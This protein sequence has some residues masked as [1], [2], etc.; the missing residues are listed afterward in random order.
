MTIEAHRPDAA[1]DAAVAATENRIFVSA[2]PGSGKTYTLTRRARRL[3]L[4]DPDSEALLLTFTNKAADE[5]RARTEDHGVHR[6]LIHG[7]TFHVFGS[8]LLAQ[9]AGR[10]EK[11]N[12]DPEF[13]II[14][15]DYRDY[16]ALTV[17]DEDG[18]PYPA[19]L[20]LVKQ[21]AYHRLRGLPV[22]GDSD[23][24]RFGARFEAAKRAEQLLDF[25]D[26]VV[27]GA[28]LLQEN[29]DIAAEHSDG[30]H[31]L[32]DELQDI[33]AMH[34]KMIRALAPAAKTIS[35]F[36]D[37]DQSIM[38]FMGSD[39]RD[40]AQLV[41]EL[42]AKRYDL[43]TNHRSGRR[44][45]DA[46]N[47][48]IEAATDG[49]TE[50]ENE[51]E[52]S[53]T[54]G[55]VDVRHCST[56]TEQARKLATEI[57]EAIAAKTIV[58]EDVAILVRNRSVADLIVPALLNRDVEV[59]DWRP[60]R[61]VPVTRRLCAFFLE[62]ALKD[63]RD[64][65]S[66]YAADWIAR[67]SGRHSGQPPR[68]VGPLLKVCA[69]A[70]VA[71]VLI[72]LRGV[73]SEPAGTT[74]VAVDG[75]EAAFSAFGDAPSDADGWEAYDEPSALD[76]WFGSLAQ[77]AH[78]DHPRVIAELRKLIAEDPGLTIGSLLNNVKQ[79]RRPSLDGGGVKVGTIQATKG[80]EWPVVYLL[81]LE[82]GR[83]PDIHAV[84]CDDDFSADE[85]DGG[86]LDEERRIC[87]VGVTRAAHRL[88]VG[89]VDHYQGFTD[90]RRGS[91]FLK[92]IRE[93]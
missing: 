77:A 11:A 6:A 20:W 41:E 30:R 42:G 80:L 61:L 44:I 28:Q 81:G 33:N 16:V 62:V 89:H 63:D 59:T 93:R 66:K 7:S 79:V 65:V 34:A 39:P 55:V 46:G 40:V 91:R 90:T 31:L 15:D 47:R 84:R 72:T 36:G 19:A 4:S 87:F 86:S 12:I 85:V 54:N 27:Y 32:V 60:S 68:H 23:L 52:K 76:Q 17:E 10:L 9:H 5:M 92:Q 2:G 8:R 14:D 22:N 70:P 1:Q 57:A 69:G 58:A 73:L 78:D 53:A 82:E 49:R 26:L 51:P 75:L 29:P 25:D 37:P 83:L 74:A 67:L 21:W 71:D 24:G 13:V 48:V 35:L 43:L 56:D 50:R 64:T 3:L 88:V 18:E 38:S 45:V